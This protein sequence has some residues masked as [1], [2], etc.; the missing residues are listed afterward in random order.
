MTYKEALKELYDNIDLI[1]E[2]DGSIK[3]Y[4]MDGVKRYTRFHTFIDEEL[5]LFFS[6][7]IANN[8]IRDI[9]MKWSD[10]LKFVGRKSN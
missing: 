9:R 7:A 4:D 5:I 1:C 6:P 3:I 2:K 8:D 10:F